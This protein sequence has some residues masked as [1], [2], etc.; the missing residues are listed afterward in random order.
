LDLLSVNGFSLLV[1]FRSRR[2]L[3]SPSVATHSLL[4]I[5]VRAGSED[6]FVETFH[7]L[8]VFAHAGGIQGFGGG[9]LL[10]PHE[11]STFV[12]HARWASAAGY[13]AWLDAPVRAT[14][15]AELAAHVDGP[16]TSALYEGAG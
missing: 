11:G 8:G 6:A 5:P 4:T 1:D 9:E 16:M 14:L 12:V 7:R 10:R 2:R 3:E 15:N 13:Q